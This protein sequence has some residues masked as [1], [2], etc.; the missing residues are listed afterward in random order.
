[1]A[2]IS[3]TPARHQRR[4]KVLKM[5]KGYFGSKST[6]YKTAHEQVMRSL[7]YAYRDRKQRKRDFRKLWISRI[8][9][10]SMLLG[11]KYSRFMYGLVLA[12]VDVN[13]KILA[14]LAYQQPDVF[15]Q[16]VKLSQASLEQLKQESNITKNTPT[17]E[18]NP[19]QEQI[20]QSKSQIAKPS[21]KTEFLKT[22]KSTS[23]VQNKGSK[24]IVVSPKQNSDA[25]VKLDYEKEVYVEKSNLSHLIS[26]KKNKPLASKSSFD[27]LSQMTFADLKQL[28]KE[29]QVT[30]VYKLK[31]NEIIDILTKK[32]IK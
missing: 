22:Q 16:Y 5:A 18:I 21:I 11:M 15:A 12:K 6:L 32:I 17:A 19:K 28:A 7:Q 27:K 20:L 24:N 31:K 30:Q 25:T 3:F 29:H 9:A 13:R 14:D 2:K 23:F 26:D 1:M 10:G 8:N 4:K